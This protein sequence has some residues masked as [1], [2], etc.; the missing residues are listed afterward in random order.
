MN[1]L[2][3]FMDAMD[4]TAACISFEATNVLGVIILLPKDLNEIYQ[5]NFGYDIHLSS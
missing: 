3:L 4:A 1:R 2:E 5:E